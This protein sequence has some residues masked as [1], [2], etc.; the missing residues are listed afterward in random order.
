VLIY[1][2]KKEQ[3]G[4]ALQLLQGEG[5]G[6]APASA[7]DSLAATAIRQ[8]RPTPHH[9]SLS[10]L[11]PSRQWN[12]G[13]VAARKT[14]ASC[15]HCNMPATGRLDFYDL[16]QSARCMVVVGASPTPL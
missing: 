11:A 3:G 6:T 13:S 10:G 1:Y 15:F 16:S 12:S 5:G 9:I 4:I 7:A 14:E 8:R 2:K